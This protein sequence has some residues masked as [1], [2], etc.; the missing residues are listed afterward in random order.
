MELDDEYVGS[1][2]RFND[3]R[4][5]MTREEEEN[6]DWDNINGAEIP[7]VKDFVK[8]CL[9]EDEI[10]HKIEENLGK[11]LEDNHTRRCGCCSTQDLIERNVLSIRE[12][13]RE[14]HK[15]IN[16]DMLVMAAILKDISR[17]ILQEKDEEWSDKSCS[18]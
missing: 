8:L 15:S 18:L 2:Y 11:P 5:M 13:I 16:N 3:G 9:V 6:V 1:S 4:R 14:L 12:E 10:W 7:I 17:V